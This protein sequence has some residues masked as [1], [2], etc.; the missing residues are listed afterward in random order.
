MEKVNEIEIYSNFLA[1]E[2]SSIKNIDEKYYKIRWEYLLNVAS[3]QT[4]LQV[5]IN[6]CKTNGYLSANDTSFSSAALIL[7]YELNRIYF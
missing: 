3:P 1:S 2:K 5:F 7:G 4:A 6:A